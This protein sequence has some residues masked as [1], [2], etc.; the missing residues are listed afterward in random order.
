MYRYLITDPAGKKILIGNKN[1][2]DLLKVQ[3]KRYLTCDA[4]HVLKY[5]ISRINMT[6]ED[7]IVPYNWQKLN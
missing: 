6:Q 2:Q 7:L 3:M 5:G 1:T 4:G